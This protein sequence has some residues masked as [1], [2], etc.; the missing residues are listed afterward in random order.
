MMLMSLQVDRII[1]CVFLGGDLEVYQQLLPRYFPSALKIE[2]QS[3]QEEDQD[4]TR[5]EESGEE[6]TEEP[7]DEVTKEEETEGMFARVTKSYLGKAQVHARTR[8]W[9]IRASLASRALCFPLLFQS[10]FLPRRPIWRSRW[11][12]QRALGAH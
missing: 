12:I 1:F 2:Q 11:E 9:G 5:K 4:E 7:S 8:V 3:D 10:S 6:I